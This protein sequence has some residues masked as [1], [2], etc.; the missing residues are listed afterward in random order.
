MMRTALCFALLGLLL[1]SCGDDEK[2]STPSGD[3]AAPARVIDLTPHYAGGSAV[4][5]SWTAPGDDGF[6]GQAARYD[7]RYSQTTMIGAGWDTATVVSSVPTPG[8]AGQRDSLTVMD[9]ANGEWFFALKAADEVPNW[10]EMSVPVSVTVADT[11]PPG[12]V[13]DLLAISASFTSVRLRWTTPGNDGA[14]GRAAEHDLRYALAPITAETWDDAAP[15]EGLPRPALPGTLRFFRVPGLAPASGQF[16]ALRTADDAGNWS[17]LSNVIER[18]TLTITISQLTFSPWEVGVM[19]TP[20]WSPNG[21]TLMAL[22]DWQTIAHYDLYLIPA[23]GGAPVELPIDTQLGYC[24]SPCWSPDGT[25]IAFVSER[26]LNQDEIFIMAATP[27]APAIQITQFGSRQLHDLAWSPDGTRIA[28]TVVGGDS[29]DNATYEIKT[30]S[31]AGGPL[32]SLA[33]GD[34]G[35]AP[36]WS[37]DGTRIAFSSSRGRNSEIYVVPAQG[38]EATQLTDDPAWDGSPSW[39]PDGTEIAFSSTR[40]GGG[41]VYVMS[42]DGRGPTRLTSDPAPEWYVSWAP[43]DS[44]IAF[45]RDWSPRISDIY[46]LTGQEA[47]RP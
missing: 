36:A 19:S 20:R 37:P 41:D 4:M 30:V 7:I 42:A 43:A 10:S 25:R 17:W 14:L 45:V 21:Q 39:S 2:P 38:G 3:T 31:A 44:R 1:A 22:A 28:C 26:V 32:I 9:L 46:V 40:S 18:S 24:D 35:R 12:A 8:A 13:T 27:G 34:P 47:A 33:G 16:F 5:L 6:D 29:P 15:V 23:A 11:V